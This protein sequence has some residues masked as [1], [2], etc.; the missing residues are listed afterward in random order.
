MKSEYL[1]HFPLF[2]RSK[3]IVIEVYSSD[4]DSK[5]QENQVMNRWYW[6]IINVYTVVLQPNVYIKTDFNR[7][8]INMFF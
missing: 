5:F 1:Y 3:D 7:P 2:C 6:I 8:I 4:D